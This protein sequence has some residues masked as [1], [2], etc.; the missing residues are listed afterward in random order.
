[1]VLGKIA[2]G[3]LI[4]AGFAL[5]FVFPDITDYQPSQM[6]WAGI[7]IGILLIAIG[8]YLLLV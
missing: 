4:L 5:I 7:F 8:A 3:A 2:G 1:L 6:S